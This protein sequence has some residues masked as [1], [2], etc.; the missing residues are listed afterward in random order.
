VD[1]ILQ[2]DPPDDPRDYIHR[3]GRTAR[4][5]GSGKGLLFLQPCELG[6]LMYLKAAK[7]PLNEYEFPVNKIANVQSQLENL[8]ATRHYIHQSAKDGYRS[9]LQAYASYSSKSIFDINKLDLVKVAKSFGFSVPPKVSH[10][11][12][13]A[14]CRSILLLE[15]VRRLIRKDEEITGHMMDLG[16]RTIP[17]NIAC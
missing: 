14:D 2:Y 10:L 16:R 5:G 12:D 3:V 13:D 8:V 6:F 11:L 1:W 17:S 9:Y 4:G 15:R 7:V